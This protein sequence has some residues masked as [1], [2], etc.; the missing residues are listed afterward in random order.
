MTN[1]RKLYNFKVLA[2]T[3]EGQCK[4]CQE[5]VDEGVSFCC[6]EHSALYKD[7]EA[8]YP[9]PD[10][11]WAPV[12]RAILAV[13]EVW[14]RSDELRKMER[15]FDAIIRRNFYGRMT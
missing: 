8:H 6:A 9:L 2:T 7:V 1:P 4:W 11:M 10:E 12:K 13:S 3:P 15:S 14:D 5:E